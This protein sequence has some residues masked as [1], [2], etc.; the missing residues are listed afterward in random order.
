MAVNDNTGNEVKKEEKMPW[1]DAAIVSI[2]LTASQFFITFMTGYPYDKIIQ[3][4]GLF[5]YDSFIF[6]GKTFFASFIALAGLRQLIKETS[7]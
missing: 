7:N 4:V 3:N 2:I 6:I 1:K 5:Y